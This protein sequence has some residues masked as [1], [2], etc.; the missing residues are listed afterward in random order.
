MKKK[1]SPG[2]FSFFPVVTRHFPERGRK[3]FPARKEET[4]R[5]KKMRKKQ[6]RSLTESRKGEIFP[7]NLDSFR[8]CRAFSHTGEENTEEKRKEKREK[9]RGRAV[10]APLTYTE[11]DRED[12]E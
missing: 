10:I 1:K 4:G 7:R 5:R 9:K 3:S 11:K 6:K 12:S 2:A 8:V